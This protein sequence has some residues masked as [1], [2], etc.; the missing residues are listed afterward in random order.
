MKSIPD[1]SLVAI[2]STANSLLPSSSWCSPTPETSSLDTQDVAEDASAEIGGQRSGDIFVGYERM[3][4]TASVRHSLTASKTMDCSSVPRSEAAGIL[5][6][7]PPNSHGT[8]IERGAQYD[9]FGNVR[10]RSGV[11]DVDPLLV[12][13]S[14]SGLT[15]NSTRVDHVSTSPLEQTGGA[16]EPSV[17]EKGKDAQSGHKETAI[18]GRALSTTGGPSPMPEHSQASTMRLSMAVPFPLLVFD[19]Q[20]F[21]A[22]GELDERFAFQGGIADWISRANWASSDHGAGISAGVGGCC[23]CCD[24]SPYRH[25]RS[26]RRERAAADCRTEIFSTCSDGEVLHVHE[27]DWGKR[28]FTPWPDGD[29]QPRCPTT[30]ESV[31]DGRP[32]GLNVNNDELTNNNLVEQALRLLGV[33][34]DGI[35]GPLDSGHAPTSDGIF[36]DQRTTLPLEELEVLIQADADLFYLPLL[37]SQP[38][39]KI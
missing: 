18:G 28:F 22:L 36:I 32:P 3:Q 30:I 6:P 24:A 38:L 17:L 21:L 9:H 29:S 35:D 31:P 39:G 12:T 16:G 23:C 14:P 13:A 10:H 27:R 8:T 20:T 4:Y 19:T 37:L 2:L 25:R 34:L 26:P 33:D 11:G 1:N 15:T 7:R 5:H